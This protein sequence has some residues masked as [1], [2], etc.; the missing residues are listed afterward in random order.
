[1]GKTLYTNELLTLAEHIGV[2]E[3]HIAEM[4]AAMSKLA[5]VC[6]VH[7]DINHFD[8]SN[9]SGFA[10]LCSTFSAKYEGQPPPTQFA[11]LDLDPGG[12]W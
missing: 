5:E 10:G 11:L 1:M 6:A 3:E 8:T 2:G 4:E 9:Q 7:L 12:K